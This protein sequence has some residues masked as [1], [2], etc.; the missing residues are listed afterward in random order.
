MYNSHSGR[1]RHYIEVKRLDPLAT[2]DY[3]GEE[4]YN[5]VMTA[6]ADVEVKSG[7][8]L[9]DFGTAL[10][11]T[12]ITVLMRYDDRM[13]NDCSIFW[14]DKVYEVQHIAPDER[15]RDMLVTAKREAR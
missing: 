14:K 11:E 2:D 4:V 13:T 8:Q 1:F 3:T 7:R 6:R 9:Q 15:E 12:V 10:T 5:D